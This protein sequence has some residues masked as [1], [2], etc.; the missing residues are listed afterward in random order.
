[1]SRAAFAGSAGAATLLLASC[2]L[3]LPAPARA[4]NP[5][6]VLELPQVQIIGTTPLPGSGV[7]LA[8]LPANAQVFTSRDLKR[9]GATTLAEFLGDNA[10]S[11]TVNAAQGNPYQ[12]DI[13]LRGFTAS[14]VLGTPQGL[15]VFLDGVRINEPFG[16]SVNWDLIAPSAISSIQVVPG[17]NPAFGLNTLGGAI[18]VYTKSGSSEYPDRPGG[19]LT[20]SGGSF[21]RRTLGFETG[22]RSGPWDWF[23][24]GQ[25]SDDRGWAEHNPSRV[26]QLFAKIGHQDDR[27]DLDL[28]VQLA[29]NR[30]EGTQT[31]PASFADIR[32]AYTWPDANTNRVA[33]A[34]LKGS[35]ALDER[36]LLSGNAYLRRFTNRSTSSNVNDDF[37]TSG[38]PQAIN[39]DSTIRQLGRGLG[40]QLARNGPIGRL[41][42]HLVVGASLDDGR[43]HFIRGAQ[44]AQF[45]ADRGTVASGDFVADTDADASTRYGGVFASDSIGLDERWTLLVA[46]RFNVARL[47]IADRS[48]VAPEL[49]GTHRYTRLNPA[50]GLTFSPSPA[51]T[52]YLS[53]SEGMRAPTA[54]E[55]TCADPAAPCKLPNNFLADPPLR[56]IVSSTFETGARGKL[57]DDSSWSAAL[58][59]TD[60][61]DDIQFIGSDTVAVNAGFFQNVGRTRR[62]GFELGAS[63]SLGRA[64]LTLRYAFVD[65]TFRTGFVG[66]SPAN[67][68]AD[69]NGAIIVRPGDRIPSIARHSLKAR[70]DI[71]ATAEWSFGASVVAAS[72]VRARGDENNRDANGS[73]AG[74]ALA[75]V[76]TR[77]RMSPRIVLFARVDNVFDRRAASVGVLGQNVFTGPGQ[78]FD[79]ANPRAEVFRGYVAPRGAWAG[80][81]YTFE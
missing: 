54:I 15:S 11:V 35:I 51:L 40:V 68:T 23:A 41:A 17:A 25:G 34:T 57:G 31:L 73:V 42:H 77:W 53:H 16:D 6:E 37:A 75:N 39:D 5:A 55:L 33:A 48:G 80:V 46:G 70:L 72:A 36:W 74:Y 78:S 26:R 76:D 3:C 58:Y 38:G 63:R 45:S 69:G 56:K 27:T 22:G 52:A 79:A 10:G 24:T 59:R 4:D 43:A 44:D 62:Q 29:D 9:Q 71:E 18:A 65:A 67:S 7:P 20:L 32:Q 13:N 21:G 61:R 2:G 49:D 30:L 1:V 60:L 47:R 50:L 64:A 14:P 12:P 8:K 19:S 28:T 66:N 81:Q